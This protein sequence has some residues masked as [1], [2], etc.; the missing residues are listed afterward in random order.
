L[1]QA[2]RQPPSDP[3]RCVFALT[4][5]AISADLTTVVTPCQL[6]GKPDCHQ[7]GCIASAALHAVSQHRLPIGIRAGAIYDVSR[8]IGLPLKALRGADFTRDAR[9]PWM[10]LRRRNTILREIRP[11]DRNRASRGGQDQEV[12]VRNS[13]DSRKDLIQIVQDSPETGPV[14]YSTLEHSPQ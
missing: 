11:T 8:A 5:R 2:Y 12:Q 3:G 6:G 7:C 9:N 4:T 10:Q 14:G 13:T 1:L